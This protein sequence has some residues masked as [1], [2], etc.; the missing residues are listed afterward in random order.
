[1][2][3]V[4]EPQV[5]LDDA[6]ARPVYEVE[7]VQ[8]CYALMAIRSLLRD[9][10]ATKFGGSA[11]TASLCSRTDA[12][13]GIVSDDFERRRSSPSVVSDDAH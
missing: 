9:L 1:M 10:E 6:E 8:A 3:G 12:V 7:R 5:G 13:G 11:P 4:Q 2:I